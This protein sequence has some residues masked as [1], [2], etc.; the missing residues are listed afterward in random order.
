MKTQT[1]HKAG[2]LRGKIVSITT[3]AIITKMNIVERDAFYMTEKCRRK[4]PMAGF[5]YLSLK[6]QYYA[7][8]R[9]LSLECPEL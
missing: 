9:I 2:E 3:F 4:Q 7:N 8:F 5:L 6:V 1:K